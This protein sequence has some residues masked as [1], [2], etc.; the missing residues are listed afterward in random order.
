VELGAGPTGRLAT[1]LTDPVR[2]EP[3]VG[4]N[5]AV[6]CAVE[7]AKTVE[8]P[9]VTLCALGETRTSPHVLI[10][11]PRFSNAT[12]PAGYG[13]PMAELTVAVKVTGS[14]VTAVSG[15]AASAVAVASDPGRMPGPGVFARAIGGAAPLSTKHPSADASTATRAMRHFTPT[16]C[17]IPRKTAPR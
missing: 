4:V 8:Q 9:T 7:A 15:D 5:T 10:G 12:F 6:S 11:E 16:Q 2:N 1:G 3:A 17:L 14:F 13:A